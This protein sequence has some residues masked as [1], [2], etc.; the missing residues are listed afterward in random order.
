MVGV[1]VRK[2]SKMWKQSL[3]ATREKEAEEEEMKLRP[4]TRVGL[5]ATEFRNQMRLES[6]QN[7]ESHHQTEE[8]HGFGQ[9]ESKN[10][11]REELLLQG[12][13]ASI[14]N[15][16]T[17]EHGSDTSSRT[18]NTDG[19]S[20]GTDELGG[21]VNVRADSAGLQR[22]GLQGRSGHLRMA[23]G[24]RHTAKGAHKSWAELS[25]KKK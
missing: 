20:T 7:Q 22:A 24:Y 19:G 5:T 13:I 6:E 14:T 1:L 17:A 11:V 10:G 2:K 23:T 21:R 8:T 4:R 25:M 15:D 18:G 3:P 12:R 16:Q 9:G